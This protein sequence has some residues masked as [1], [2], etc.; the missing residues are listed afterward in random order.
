MEERGSVHRMVSVQQGESA[1][2]RC[3][4]SF[5]GDVFGPGV[6]RICQVARGREKLPSRKAYQ[7]SGGRGEEGM[8]LCAGSCEC[9]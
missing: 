5:H 1:L 8:G 3:S 4:T 2:L 7:S 6:R 9:E